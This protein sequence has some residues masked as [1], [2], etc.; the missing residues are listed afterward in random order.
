LGQNFCEEGKKEMSLEWKHK[1][2]EAKELVKKIDDGSEKLRISYSEVALEEFWRDMVQT[3]ITKAN[4]NHEEMVSLVCAT[5]YLI[6]ESW[7][8]DK[9]VIHEDISPGDG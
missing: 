1:I 3:I 5:C 9:T 7:R 8:K 6:N 2:E 4:S